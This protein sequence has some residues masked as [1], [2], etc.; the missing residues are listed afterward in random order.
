MP[1]LESVCLESTHPLIHLVG[2]GAGSGLPNGNG[3]K[4]SGNKDYL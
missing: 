3:A 2:Y 1:Y 4:S